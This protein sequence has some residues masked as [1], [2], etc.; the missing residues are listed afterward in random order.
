MIGKEGRNFVRALCI[1]Y[2]V[3]GP[4][5]NIANNGNEITRVFAC[6]TRLTYNLTKTRFDLMTRPLES[7]LASAK[8]DV[9]QV[10]ETFNLIKSMLDPIIKEIE[11]DDIEDEGENRTKRSINEKYKNKLERRCRAQLQRGSA[12]CRSAFKST[13]DSCMES[14]PKVIN[15]ILCWPLR[16]DF[17]C[18]FKIIDPDKACIPDDTIVDPEL[19]N[20]YNKLKKLVNET[21]SENEKGMQLEYKVVMPKP[22]NK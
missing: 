4:I 17:I 5:V 10:L 9:A 19:E 22:S 3:F 18:D 7:A 2:L 21:I 11:S 13:M 1:S 20:S 12:K 8:E 15:Y 6:S 14:L 16:I